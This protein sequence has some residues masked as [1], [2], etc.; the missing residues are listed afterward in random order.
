MTEKQKKNIATVPQ[1]V[2]K[3]LRLVSPNS[4]KNLLASL[5]IDL[6][7]LFVVAERHQNQIKELL[8]LK[9]PRDKG[10]FEKLLGR[11]E[12]NLLFESNW[13]LKSLKRRLPRLWDDMSAGERTKKV[14]QGRH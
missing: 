14:R 4:S 3:Q 7:D 9:L 8:R 11:L 5:A 6:H 13:H 1:Q 2:L 10:K 12:V